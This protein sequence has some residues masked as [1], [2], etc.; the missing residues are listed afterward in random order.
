MSSL[1]YIVS[2]DRSMLVVDSDLEQWIISIRRHIHEHPE[3]SLEENNTSVFVQQK[4]AGLG[5]SSSGGHGGTGVVAVI[6]ENEGTLCVGLRADMDALPVVEKTGLPFS[7]SMPGVMH[8][9]GHDGHIAML[10]GAAVLLK[11]CESIP[12]RVKL[13]FQPAEEHGNGAAR[14][15]EEGV[16]DDVGVVFG[17]HVDTHYPTGTITVDKGI[18]CAYTD[19]FTVKITGRGGHAA[20]P[21]EAADAVVAASSLVLMIQT[22]ISRGVDPNKAEVIT[23]GS[24]QAGSACN[25]IAGEALLKGTIR[26]TDTDTRI[27][28]IEGLKRVVQSIATMHDVEAELVFG[29]GLPAVINSLRATDTARSAAWDIVAVDG[30]ISQGDPSLGGEDFS[31]YQ[32]VTEGCMVNFGAAPQNEVGPAHSNTFDFDEACL[33]VGARWYAAVALRWLKQQDPVP[34]IS[35]DEDYGS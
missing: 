24:F 6:G 21:H 22:L 1:P 11:R 8:A 15:V 16:L 25:V 30:V 28:T 10:L 4:L 20:R 26:S 3:L 34:G 12:G 14:L 33:K 19:P 35:E 5:I 13:I 7:S 32:Q 18:I 23:I 29:E 17:G 2:E 31:F 27:Q 9:C